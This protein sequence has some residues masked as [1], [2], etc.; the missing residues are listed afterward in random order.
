VLEDA[1]R[2]VLEDPLGGILSH[3]GHILMAVEGDHVVGTCA[4]IP[5]EPGEFE[6]AKMAVAPE[7]RGRG[8][9]ELLGRAAI[10]RA[11][12]LGAQRVELLS[13]TALEPAIRLY[14]KLGFVEV[15]LG[16]SDYHRANIRMVREV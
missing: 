9:G 1:D 15:P 4:L 8:I 3:G 11:A 13:N 2:R 7:A 14:R 16:S 5:T 12:M 10:E 6:L